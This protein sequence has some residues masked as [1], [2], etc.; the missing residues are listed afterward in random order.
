MLFQK[1]EDIPHVLL[2]AWV[3]ERPGGVSNVSLSRGGVEE[4]PLAVFGRGVQD[5][6]AVLYERDEA[7]GNKTEA[8]A[9]LLTAVR[10]EGQSAGFHVTWF[11]QP[12][13]VAAV[14]YVLVA[15]NAS[16]LH[17]RAI[18]DLLKAAT[19]GPALGGLARPQ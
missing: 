15:E 3:P 4:T 9:D 8:L 19:M 14:A 12:S 13:S 10:D 18:R 7:D 1:A 17:K 6:V 5:R 2:A 11:Y 16:V